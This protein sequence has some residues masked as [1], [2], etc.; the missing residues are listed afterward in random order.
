MENTGY[1]IQDT[2][3][4]IHRRELVLPAIQREFV[5][6][7]NQIYSLF[8][9]LMQEYPF[10]TFLHWKIKRENCHK[11]KFYEFVRDYHV[12]DGAECRPLPTIQDQP[13]TA[14][15][16]GQQRLTA[17]NIGLYGSM[18][19]KLKYKSR[20]NP[21]AYPISRLHIDLLWIADEDSTDGTK[22]RF[23]FLTDRQLGTWEDPKSYWFPVHR[24]LE[25]EDGGPAM[26]TWLEQELGQEQLTQAHIPLY[27]LFKIVRETKLIVSYEERDQNLEKV[28]QIFIRM[29]EGGTKLTHSDLLFSVAVAQWNN[30]AREEIT[31]LVKSLN[32][33]GSNGFNFTKDLVLKAGLM[34]S[35]IGSVRFKGDNFNRNNMKEF[36]QNWNNIKRI[37]ILTVQ[38]VSKFGFSSDNLHAHNAILPIAY[39]LKRRNFN[40]SYLTTPTKHAEDRKLVHNWLVRSLLKKGTWGSGTDTLLTALRQ[41]IVESTGDEFPAAQIQATMARQGKSLVFG[42]EELEDLVNLKYGDSLTF[43]LL[44]L[45]FPFIDLTGKF[46]IDHIFPK[47]RFTR[48]KLLEAKVPEDKVEEYI[49]KKDGLGNLQL[50]TGEA[51]SEKSRKMPAVWLSEAYKDPKSRQEYIANHLLGE[52]PISIV[53]FDQFYETRKI[54]LKENFRELLG[55]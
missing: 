25:F 3:E 34:L 12:K 8:D 2:L 38:L 24:V 42:E 40:D 48:L 50:L 31:R 54:R 51:N 27:K 47:S 33:I 19:L 14:V 53:D 49:R 21:N 1:T 10:G 6:K 39:Y 23:R 55:Q 43:A 30:D 18:A 45:I 29:N 44:S 26:S 28:L 35:D 52:V 11:F 37:L 32:K 46:H 22:F 41:T 20:T 4:D 13:L 5:W 9:S 16:D 7:P 17:L 36:E 15:L